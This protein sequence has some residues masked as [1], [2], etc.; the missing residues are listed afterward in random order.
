MNKYILTR[1]KQTLKIK[2]IKV[3]VSSSMKMKRF[4]ESTSKS[5]RS[6]NRDRQWFHKEQK[7]IITKY[8]SKH[9]QQFL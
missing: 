8:F 1:K 4:V 3:N 9:K 5:I 2:K 7:A 6:L